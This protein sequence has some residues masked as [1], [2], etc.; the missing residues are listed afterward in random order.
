MKQDALDARRP[1]SAGLLGELASDLALESDLPGLLRRFL[2]PILRLTGADAGAVRA[3]SDNDDRLQLVGF[4]GLREDDERAERSVQRGCGACGAA[5][6]AGSPIWAS[7]SGA[8]ARLGEPPGRAGARYRRMVAVPLHHRGRTL[9]VY[10]LFFTAEEPPTAQVIAE[11]KAV[12]DLLGLA[13]NNSRLEREQLRA[14][15]VR[16]RQTMAA[17][18]HDSIAQTLTFVKMRLPLLDQAVKS[19]DTSSAVKYLGDLRGA[20]GEA[21]TSLRAII[22][23]FRLP[24]DPLGLEHAL[25]ERLNVLRERHGIDARLANEVPDLALPVGAES[26][27]VQIVSEA[28]ANIARHACATQAWLTVAQREGRVE[29]RVEDDGCGLPQTADAGGARGG[30]HGIEIMRERARRIGGDLKLQPRP[31]SGTTVR[32]S[33]PAPGPTIRK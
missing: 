10:N 15:A 14:T 1:G 2:V 18:V 7:E 30:H 24:P 31:G 5:A 9:G 28:L 27:V 4:V 17:E 8:C 11:L 26:Q 12:G 19:G 16:E 32:L 13:L 23:E 29:V 21:H 33:F 25:R 3:V 22:N 6:D 20:V